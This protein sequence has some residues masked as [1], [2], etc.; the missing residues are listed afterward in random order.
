MKA[1][2]MIGPLLQGFFVEHLLAHKHV[3]PKTVSSYRDTFRMLLQFVRDRTHTEPAS[4]RVAAL[5]APV[6]LSFLDHLE[7]ERYNSARSRNARLAAIRSFFRWAALCD[8]ELA[9]LATRV[10]AI[11]TKR[12]DRRLVQSLSRAEIDAVLAAPDR[13]QWRGRRDHALLLTLYNTGARVSEITALQQA[14][15]QFGS[16]TVINLKGKGRKERT[17][18]LWSNTARILKAW[19]HEMEGTHT[20]IAFPSHRGRQLSRNGVDYILQQAV[21]RAS[22]PCSSLVG[23]RISPHV[24]RHTTGAHL[25]QAGIDISIIALCRA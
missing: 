20:S 17:I 22:S 23:K 1:T 15:V 8:P 12:T 14:Q 18:P 25:L 6:I 19:F 16:T 21:S 11:P 9:G 5:D 10:L 2:T 3:S 4:L 7:S 24:I 13:S